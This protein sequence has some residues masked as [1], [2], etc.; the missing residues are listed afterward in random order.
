MAK[1]RTESPYLH[2]R[3]RNAYFTA[4]LS[5]GLTLFFLGLFAGLALLGGAY[6]RRAEAELELKVFVHDGVNERLLTEFE[7]MLRT[8]TF[9]QN[10][11]FVSKED[12]A[13][14][15]LE[16]TGEDVSVLLDGVNPLPAS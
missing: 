8:Q 10:L 16:E 11:R 6:V 7:V 12:A 1:D 5:I 9:V 14:A 13:R 4:L 3:S 2:T 15:M